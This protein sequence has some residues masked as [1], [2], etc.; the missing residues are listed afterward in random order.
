MLY[1]KR[2]R[3]GVKEMKDTKRL[4][5][6]IP[7]ELHRQIKLK[8]YQENLTIKQKIINLVKEWLNDSY[9]NK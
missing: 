6:E 4:I 8:A 7:I 5:V 3:K 2:I 1:F 9:A